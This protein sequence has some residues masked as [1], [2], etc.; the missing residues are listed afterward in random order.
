MRHSAL[1]NSNNT[2]AVYQRAGMIRKW[3]EHFLS[4][5][6]VNV[7]FPWLLKADFTQEHFKLLLSDQVLKLHPSPAPSRSQTHIIHHELALGCQQYDS[8]AG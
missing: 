2:A 1:T 4:F 3:F 6:E 7:C 5:Y 8:W